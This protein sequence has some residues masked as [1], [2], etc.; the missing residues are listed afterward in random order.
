MTYAPAQM[1]DGTTGKTTV[2]EPSREE[3]SRRDVERAVAIA[4]AEKPQP[5]DG[6]AALCALLAAKGTI[7]EDEAAS[8]SGRSK[9]ELAAE[10]EAWAV[11]AETSPSAETPP[12][13]PL[14]RGLMAKRLTPSQLAL[15]KKAAAPTPPVRVPAPRTT[16]PSTL[17]TPAPPHHAT[18]HG[19][20]SATDYLWAAVLAIIL[21]FTL[22]LV[23]I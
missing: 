23:L 8:L 13:T 2:V 1:I 6:H 15:G 18:D 19:R 7:T 5:L 14:A 21:I 3:Q 20:F 11:A 10:A 17:S 9:A 4:D 12:P 22:L 16:T